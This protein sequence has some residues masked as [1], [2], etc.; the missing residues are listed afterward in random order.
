MK[1]S[2]SKFNNILITG[3]AG[4]IGS[5][6]LERLLQKKITI[7]VV[8]RPG[9]DKL[10]LAKKYP[11]VKI[12]E[13]DGSTEGLLSILRRA[14][15][16]IVFHLA[17]LFISEHSSTDI[18]PLIGSN[19]LFGTQ[20]LEAMRVNQC[21][22]LV[23]TGTSWQHFQNKHYSPVNLYAA[24]KQAFEDIIEYYASSTELKVIT[25]KLFDTYGPEDKRAKL[26]KLLHDSSISGRSITMS[27]GRQLI[28]LVYIDDVIDAYLKAASRIARSKGKRIENFSVSSGKPLELRR[29]VDIYSK[30]SGRNAN[31]MWGGRTYRDREVM[32]PWNKGKRLP[33]WKPKIGL[34]EGIRKLLGK[35]KK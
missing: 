31:V 28:D 6:L 34:V 16:D 17:S 1:R 4:F 18:N 5:H 33:G 8:V 24:T 13:H 26:F 20:L 32:I 30:L 25:L 29:I 14:K 2:N 22:Y 3:A 11:I 12:F 35:E 15:P 19:V 21:N 7:S 23:N 9:A 10:L 27:P